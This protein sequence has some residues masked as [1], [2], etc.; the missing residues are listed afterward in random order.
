MENNLRL[1]RNLALLGFIVMIAANIVL[2]VVIYTKDTKTILVPS[3]EQRLEVTTKTAS[4]EYLKLRAAE[5]HHL[6][7]GMNKGNADKVKEL[8]LANV[9]NG[10][11]KRFKEQIEKLAE[12][13]KKKEYYYNFSDI[14]EYGINEKK[15][16]VKISGY[17]ETYIGDQRINREYKS[18]LYQFVNRGGVVLLYS[19]KEVGDDK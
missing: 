15:S 2:G 13:I 17:L 1:Q 5:V 16:Q 10:L 8:L 12:D 11:R 4:Q 18:Y 9:D 3:I 6:L 14:V 19:F 7:F